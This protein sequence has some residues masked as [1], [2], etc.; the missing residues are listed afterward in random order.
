MSGV[1]MSFFILMGLWQSLRPSPSSSIMSATSGLCCS[2]SRADY[3]V[4][5]SSCPEER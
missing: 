4:Q 5:T 3:V 2:A 1:M